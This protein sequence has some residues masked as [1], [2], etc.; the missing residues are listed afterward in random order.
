MHSCKPYGSAGPRTARRDGARASPRPQ[1]V[2]GHSS[3][4]PL[5]EYPQ[6]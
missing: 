3:L 4:H 6:R 2:S 1:A 5:L